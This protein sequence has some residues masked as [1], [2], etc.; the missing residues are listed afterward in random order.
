[1]YHYFPSSVLDLATDLHFNIQIIYPD[2]IFAKAFTLLM[3]ILP[4]T[5]QQIDGTHETVK[6]YTYI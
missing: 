3:N 6:M 5:R 2:A 4:L 1:M